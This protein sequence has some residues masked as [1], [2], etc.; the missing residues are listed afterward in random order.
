MRPE[1]YLVTMTDDTL[2]DEVVKTFGIT[3]IGGKQDAF[4]KAFAI[5]PMSQYEDRYS[6]QIEISDKVA[7][8]EI[9]Y[10]DSKTPDW[11]NDL[12]Q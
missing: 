11:V 9:P 7:D 6:W 8:I 12:P 5:A 1:R 4:K 3:T 2:N 10:N